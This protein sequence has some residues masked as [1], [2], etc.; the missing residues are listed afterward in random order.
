MSTFI[1]Y[2][3]LSI[4]VSISASPKTESLAAIPESRYSS[5]NHLNV[6]G[7]PLI[8][9]M[10][11]WN[12]CRRDERTNSFIASVVGT[13]AALFRVCVQCWVRIV[14]CPDPTQGWQEEVRMA[15]CQQYY[16]AW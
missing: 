2:G 6:L 1:F 15:S 3:L 11:K 9:V 14:I 4:E 13:K 16:L 8:Q 7:Y 10:F 12:A 5:N